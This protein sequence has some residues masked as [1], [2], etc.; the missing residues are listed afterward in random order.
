MSKRGYYYKIGWPYQS[1]DSLAEARRAARYLIKK[2]KAKHLYA[3][4]KGRYY[5]AR[6]NPEAFTSKNFYV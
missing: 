3:D 6:L 5:I 2:D 4:E 1:F